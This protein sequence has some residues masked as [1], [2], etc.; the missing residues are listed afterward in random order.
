VS[1]QRR[2]PPVS[3]PANLETGFHFPPQ[4]R[5]AHEDWQEF[6]CI[7]YVP[8]YI[9][10][11][12]LWRNHVTQANNVVD[13]ATRVAFFGMFVFFSVT[14][15]CLSYGLSIQVARGEI[16]LKRKTRP[17]DQK[18]KRMKVGETAATRWSRI[19][20]FR[21]GICCV[22]RVVRYSFTPPL[23]IGRG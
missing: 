10:T 23:W 12:L 2:R 17:R 8:M 13:P 18:K 20:Q 19:F 9:H 15:N 11:Y 3:T 7:Q 14:L 21:V 4:P 6:P 5:T 1:T 16:N 22:L